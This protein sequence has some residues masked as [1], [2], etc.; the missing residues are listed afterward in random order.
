LKFAQPTALGRKVSDEFSVPLCTLHHRELH[1]RGDERIWWS[2][3]N[4][5]ALKIAHDI[6]LTRRRPAS[7]AEEVTDVRETTTATSAKNTP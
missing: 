2:A 4:I 5:D 6:W 7:E 1:Q 3:H